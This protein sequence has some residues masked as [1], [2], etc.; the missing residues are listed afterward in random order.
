MLLK[1]SV[2][3]SKRTPHFTI[4]KLN[5]LTVFKGIIA[6]Y[7]DN[8]TEPTNIKCKRYLTLKQLVH[9]ATIRLQKVN[10]RSSALYAGC[11]DF[12]SWPA[13]LVAVTETVVV[14]IKCCD[15]VL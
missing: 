1:N 13:L 6:V 7:S 9:I 15:S 8:H 11:P 10:E 4:T 5:W 12:E 14:F 2:R 3:T